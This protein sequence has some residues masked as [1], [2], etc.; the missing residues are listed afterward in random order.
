M[1][2]LVNLNSKT[3]TFMLDEVDLD[4]KQGTLYYSPRLTPEGATQYV[5]L[6]RDAVQTGD[7]S[8]LRTALA[9]PG[10]LKAHEERST[11]RGIITARVPVTAPDTLAE[12]EF[13]R[14]YARGLCRHAIDQGITDVEI[15]RA[16]QVENPRPESSAMVGALINASDLLTDLRT[17]QGVEP[18]LGL[19]RGPNSGLSVKLVIAMEASP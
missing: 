11:A 15:Y 16:K 8:T 19:P 12:G 13:N 5:A 6:L 10:V 2:N 3:R 1:L 4:V 18:A 14:F 9:K 7:D 17:H